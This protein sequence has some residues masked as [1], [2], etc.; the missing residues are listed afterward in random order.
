MAYS[1]TKQDSQ[2]S[3]GYKEIYVDTEAD[4]ADVPTTYLPGSQI[5]VRSGGI[6]YFLT[7][8]RQWKTLEDS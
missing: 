7:N 2:E 5:L 8:D 4:V 1:I 6:V 3:Y